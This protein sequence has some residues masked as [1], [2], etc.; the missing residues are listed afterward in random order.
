VFEGKETV[1]AV[2]FV[3]LGGHAEV[4]F[5]HLDV[6]RYLVI[7]KVA[8][9]FRETEVALFVVGRVPVL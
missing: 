9:E 2:A 7:D 5:P 6:G 3:D 4:L 1:V 8:T